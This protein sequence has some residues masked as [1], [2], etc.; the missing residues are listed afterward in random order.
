MGDSFVTTPIRA[1]VLVTCA[2][3]LAACGGARDAAE[4]SRAANKYLWNASL[5]TL[6]F[7]PLQQADPFSGVLVTGY[8]A[9]PGAA[10]Q[11][12][13]TI[14]VTGAALEATSLKVALFRR[15][16]GRDVPAATGTVVEVENAILARARQLRIRDARL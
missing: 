9:A 2:L 13:A 11:Y 14:Y 6:S 15:S 3:A 8:G 1:L 4:T 16:G 7:L 10:Q 5:E 12:R